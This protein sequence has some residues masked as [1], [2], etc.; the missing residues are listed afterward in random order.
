[1]CDLLISKKLCLSKTKNERTSSFYKERGGVCF[2]VEKQEGTGL[3]EDG[4]SRRM[5]QS[6][7]RPNSS[8][9]GPLSFQRLASP[10]RVLGR[11]MKVLLGG[12]DKTENSPLGPGF[13]EISKQLSLSFQDAEK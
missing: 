2:N 6:S 13:N 3:T 5:L 7:L 11:E 9:R 10:D 12:L 8:A 4:M 1:M